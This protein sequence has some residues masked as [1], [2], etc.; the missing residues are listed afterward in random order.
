MH[1]VS[2]GM[3]ERRALGCERCDRFDT[4]LPIHGPAQLR[5]ILV[6]L[7]EAVQSDALTC[8]ATGSKS[9]VIEQKRFMEL[10]LDEDL[11][12]ALMYDFCC[13]QCNARFGLRVECFHGQGGI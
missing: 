6:K 8:T 4:E 2:S 13:S 11:P 10:R 3:I 12:D 5:R 1:T 7:Q 9:L